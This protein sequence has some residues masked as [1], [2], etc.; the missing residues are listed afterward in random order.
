[1]L[2]KKYIHLMRLSKPVGIFLLLWPTMWALWISA[3]GHPSSKNIFIFI[4][5]VILMRSAGCV[6]NDIADKN[7]DLYVERTKNR[8]IATGEI[9]VH[10]AKIL[11]FVLLLMSFALVLL[12]NLYTI[13]ISI[14]ALAVS[15]LYP[16][17]KRFFDF[18]QL[19]L[20]FAFSFGVPMAFTA[21]KM[22]LTWI[23]W[24]LMVTNI[25]WVIMYDTEYALT[26]YADDLKIGLKSSAILFGQHDRLIIGLL[27]L[28]V[29]GLFLVLG[30][31]LYFSVWYFLGVLVAALLFIHQQ[32]LIQKRNPLRCFSAFLNNHWVGL[33]IFLGIFFGT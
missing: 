6:I 29:I 28:I 9:S 2:I 14:L 3:R 22:P 15:M 8:P 31:C 32:H 33:V 26:D 16:L 7:F 17:M 13:L 12:T 21:E 24:I 20:G 11:F 1:M 18:P 5:G 4:L 30:F 10:H 25:F 27:Q 19:V 23:T